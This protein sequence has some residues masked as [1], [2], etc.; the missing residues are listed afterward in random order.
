MALA[1]ESVMRS[2][3]RFTLNVEK[4]ELVMKEGARDYLLAATGAQIPYDQVSPD[5]STVRR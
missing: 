5:G 2:Q 1:A 3:L 4:K